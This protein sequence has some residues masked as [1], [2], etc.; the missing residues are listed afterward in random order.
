MPKQFT[1][2]QTG[3]DGRAVQPRECALGAGAEFVH[4][5]RD[6]LLAGAGFAEDQNG[7]VGGRDGFH[8]AQRFAE[9]RTVA[10]HL[11]EVALGANLIF[12]VELLFGELVLQ[13]LDLADGLSVLDGDGRLSRHLREK[14]DVFGGEG[15]FAHAGEVHGAQ[16]AVARS[17]RNADA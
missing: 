4:A 1:L 11:P 13:P 16:H 14:I 3:R 7:S 12:K 17:Q 2:Q 15:I 9:C 8:L 6:Q 10:D 5:A